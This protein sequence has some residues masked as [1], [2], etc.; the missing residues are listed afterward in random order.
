MHEN[1]GILSWIQNLGRTTLQN[2]QAG[3]GSFGTGDML[4][5]EG[6]IQAPTGNEGPTPPLMPSI[7]VPSGF[8]K[9]SGYQITQPAS[10]SQAPAPAQTR[11]SI[12]ASTRAQ[13]DPVQEARDKLKTLSWQRG[14]PIPKM[15]DRN[16][17]SYVDTVSKPGLDEDK[18]K[19]DQRAAL[20]RQGRSPSL[21]QDVID[22]YRRADRERQAQEETALSPYSKEQRAA[23]AVQNPGNVAKQLKQLETPKEVQQDPGAKAAMSLLATKMK[24]DPDP[25]L[26][27]AESVYVKYRGEVDLKFFDCTD[28]TRSSFIRRV[29]YDRHNEYMLI[30]L[31]GTFY[32]YCAIDAGTVSSFLS[33]PS[34]GK[35]YNASIRGNFDCRLHQV[36][37]Y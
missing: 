22:Q 31:N 17:Q 32:H 11:E 7:T 13:G 2:I 12:E 29:C 35:L 34:M 18:R 20:I 15:G 6:G 26:A 27:R 14:D 21:P 25:S 16:F 23:A 10:Q 4:P 5:T 37:G 24:S 9:A 28:I 3:N 8:G 36:P 19:A 33:A 30:S 1:G